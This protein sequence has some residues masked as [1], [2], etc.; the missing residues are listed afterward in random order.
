MAVIEVSS[1][2]Q[3]AVVSGDT[4]LL[5]VYTALPAGL[6]PPFPPV[7]LPGGLDG[8]IQRGGFGQNFFFSSE[9][10]GASFE[11]SSGEVVQA[12]GKTVKNVQG[13]DLVRPLIGSF[14]RLGRVHEA[15]LRLRPGL[16]FVHVAREGTLED[17]LL[18]EPRFA[19]QDGA[20]VHTVLFGH[21][22]AVSAF[23]LAFGGA[24]VSEKLDYRSRFALGM[25]VGAG[26][27]RDSRFGWVEGESAPPMPELFTALM[28]AMVAGSRK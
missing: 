9:V 16:A 27:L 20:Q 5:E 24:R 11:T 25:G 17:A 12:G 2:N 14:G 7:E 4:P 18:L 15:T 26:T 21:A 1:A 8:L 3:Y 10:L 6:Y 28:G 22:R 19:W 23:E 13:F